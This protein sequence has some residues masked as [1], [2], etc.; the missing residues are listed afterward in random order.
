MMRFQIGIGIIL[1]ITPELFLD[2]DLEVLKT[3]NRKG[4]YSPTTDKIP[5]V[6][7]Q[8]EFPKPPDIIIQNNEY[9][10][11]EKSVQK[12]IDYPVKPKVRWN[13]DEKY[14]DKYYAPEA[15]KS[16]LMCQPSLFACDMLQKYMISGKNLIE[17]G[18][19]N[20]R[21]S[22]YLAENGLN[23]IGIDASQ[24]VLTELQHPASSRNCTFC[25]CR[26]CEHRSRPYQI[27][28][29]YCY[30]RFTFSCNQ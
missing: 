11:L 28:Y 18:R 14:W 25:T 29:D 2:V 23:V 1:N 19:G 22:I 5:G 12:I 17:L 10:I 6:N 3:T 26:F 9:K 13:K 16:D 4:L 20:G 30:S 27:Q 21:D 24:V 8:V 7:V 15:A